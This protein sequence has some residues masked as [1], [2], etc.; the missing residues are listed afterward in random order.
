MILHIMTL[1]KFTPLF[2]HF[3]EENIGCRG[4]KFVFITSKRFQYGLEE[5]DNAEFLH[6]DA[7]FCKLRNYMFEAEK[8]NPSQSEKRQSPQNFATRAC[9]ISKINLGYVG[10][11]FLFT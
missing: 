11:R 10:R 3:V 8:N 1:E 4:H 7:D 6:T 5:K 9:I 2:I